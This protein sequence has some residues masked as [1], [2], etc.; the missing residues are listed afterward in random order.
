VPLAEDAGDDRLA[1]FVE[2]PLM[3]VRGAHCDASFGIVQEADR[4]TPAV[5][6]VALDE[7]LF[8]ELHEL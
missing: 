1:L 3:W 2:E 4:A 6:L 7:A 8:R 5:A